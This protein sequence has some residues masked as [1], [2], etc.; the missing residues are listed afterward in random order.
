[1]TGRVIV[2]VVGKGKKGDRLVSA[3]NGCARAAGLEECTP[4]NVIGR[5]LADKETDHEETVMCVV[6]VNK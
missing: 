1:M 4:F 3:G 6:N 2:R 5:L